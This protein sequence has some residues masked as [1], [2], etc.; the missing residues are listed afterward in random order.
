MVTHS[1]GLVSYSARA[2]RVSGASTILIA[3]DEDEHAVIPHVS[4]LLSL[5]HVP[6]RIMPS[7]FE[8]VYAA[9]SRLGNVDLPTVLTLRID[10]LDRAQLAC[11]RMLDV[12]LAT[13]LMVVILPLTACLA[14]IIKIDSRGPVFYKQER[15]GRNGRRFYMFK[16][17]TM[18]A[19]ADALLDQLAAE[20][21][22]A[23]DGGR[24]FKIRDDPRITRVGRF[25][26]RSSLDELP[27]VFNVYR[28]EMSLV[29]PRP[30]LPREVQNYEIHHFCRLKGMP[31]IT[32]LWQVSGRSELSFE[33][34]V[35][36]DQ[37][38]LENWSLAL[39]LSILVK[40][41]SVVLRRKGAY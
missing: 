20:N 21:E 28:G 17:R 5:A 29:G 26:R 13:G 37:Y 7:L 10:P 23:E 8:P 11:K 35:R 31:G 16:F 24:L 30:P 9:S 2:M 25:L 36:L 39:D 38:Y 41:V 15:V 34:M 33:E 14:L 40:T 32:G 22:V 19:E 1:A 12:I 3:L 27:Q 18:V 4:R 6:Y